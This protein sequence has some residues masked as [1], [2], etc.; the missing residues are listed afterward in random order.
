MINDIFIN[1]IEDQIRI[2]ELFQDL[3]LPEKQIQEFF[4]S[5][6]LKL[7]GFQKSKLCTLIDTIAT[8]KITSPADIKKM[9]LLELSAM[10]VGPEYLNQLHG[11][12]NGLT[13]L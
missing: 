10:L 5:G 4:Y 11:S 13:V 6:N 1:N 3:N 12:L 7:S 2:R 8:D 9:Q